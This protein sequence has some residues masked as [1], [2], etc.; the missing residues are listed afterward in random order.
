MNVQQGGRGRDGA[1]TLLWRPPWRGVC[2]LGAEGVSKGETRAR[3][4]RVSRVRTR[5]DFRVVEC[6]GKRCGDK[7]IRELGRA[8]G[9]L[10]KRGVETIEARLLG[11]QSVSRALTV[12]ALAGVCR[13]TSACGSAVGRGGACYTGA[14]EIDTRNARRARCR[15]C[16]QGNAVEQRASE[17]ADSGG[18]THTRTANKDAAGA[19]AAAGGG[20]VVRKRGRGEW[21]VAGSDRRVDGVDFGRCSS[22]LTASA[23]A[24]TTYS[25]PWQLCAGLCCCIIVLYRAC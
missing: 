13:R 10:S 1:R 7:A 2:M 19:G 5:Q 24:V 17:R 8:T 18:G 20:A 15:G 22:R 14:V 25:L 21:G 4:V 9:V 6:W 16:G 11:D 3:A 23:S 12:A